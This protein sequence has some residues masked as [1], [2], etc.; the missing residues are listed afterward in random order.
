MIDEREL[1]KL[2]EKCGLTVCM[3]FNPAL[4]VP[5]EKIRGYCLENK[6]GSYGRNYMC[7]PDVGTLEE[8]ALKLKKYSCAFLLQYSKAMDVR[9][10]NVK[11][12]VRTKKE[13]HKMVLK[14]EAFL[15]DHGIT[16]TWGLIGGNCGLC[17]TCGVVTGHPCRH[18]KKARASLEAIGID[19][20]ALVQ[21]LGLPGQ[22]RSDCIT[23]TGAVL[24][25][26]R[27]SA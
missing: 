10:E 21:T 3:E 16:D 15:H 8:I 22:F 5:E 25:N 11:K 24:Y 2:T 23:W 7:P 6:C 26:C 4:L 1:R 20:M 18:P 9:P 14:V 19:V 17:K 13:F 27:T 12:V